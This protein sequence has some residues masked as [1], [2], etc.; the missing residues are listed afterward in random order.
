MLRE[1]SSNN[2]P[3]LYVALFLL[4]C[5]YWPSDYV[6]VLLLLGCLPLDSRYPW[7][8]TASPLYAIRYPL[9]AL[10]FLL[11]SLLIPIHLPW[12]PPTISPSAPRYY[13]PSCFIYILHDKY[14]PRSCKT[15]HSPVLI[16]T[17]HA[18]SLTPPP[19]SLPLVCLLF[20]FYSSSPY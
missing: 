17:Q 12:A 15:L 14:V 1:G 16:V 20:H 7:A 9:Y 5:L 8:L 18:S 10:L 19:M 13:T 11:S 2:V 6:V 4:V 3:V